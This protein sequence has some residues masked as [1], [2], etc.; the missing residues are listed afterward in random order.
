MSRYALGELH[1]R[2]VPARTRA[3]Q[4]PTI[5]AAFVAGPLAAYLMSPTLSPGSTVIAA[6]APF[7]FGL[8]LFLG[9][10][11]WVGFGVIT[12]ITG[13]LVRIARGRGGVR[14]KV[15]PGEMLVP[16]GSPS[17][18]LLGGLVGAGLGSVGWL[19]SDVPFLTGFGGWLGLG[20]AYGAALWMAAHNGFLPFPEDD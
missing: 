14:Q 3:V 13:G 5:L 10:L 6:V 8:V 11:L 9:I 17:F 15:G 2:T 16:A 1:M 18:V 7:A 19:L 4:I 20:L 12:V